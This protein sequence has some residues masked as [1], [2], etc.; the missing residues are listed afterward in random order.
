ME[1]EIKSLME[2]ALVAC[3]SFTFV[4]LAEAALAG[5]MP[6]LAPVD[7]SHTT[8]V[9]AAQTNGQASTTP[10]TQT[11]TIVTQTLR[12]NP[13]YGNY[14]QTTR[15]ETPVVKTRMSPSE[16]APKRRERF[17]LAKMDVRTSRV[18]TPV[19]FDRYV[20]PAR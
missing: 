4:F 13:D 3:S 10:T 18:A 8:R 5:N 1:N 2:K 19:M 20:S 16:D 7:N 11:R 6:N 17:N 15:V 9:A 14:V 12:H